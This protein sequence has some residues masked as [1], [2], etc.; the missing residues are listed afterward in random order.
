MT[1][2]RTTLAM[3]GRAFRRAGTLT[4]RNAEIDRVIHASKADIMGES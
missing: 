2:L 1:W 3:Y 4:L